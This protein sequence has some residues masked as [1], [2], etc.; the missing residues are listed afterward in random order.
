MSR[1]A[2]STA[3]RESVS[4]RGFALLIT[5]VL[6]AFLVLVLVSLASFTRVETRIAANTQAIGQARQ[7][8]LQALNIAFGQL[9]KYA[10]PDQRVTA[11][12][13]ISIASPA[14]G[15]SQW[16]GVWGNSQ[17]SSDPATSAV[18]LNWLVS[19]NEQADFTASMATTDFGR[20]TAPGSGVGKTPAMAWDTAGATATEDDDGIVL[21]RATSAGGSAGEVIAP[22]VTVTVPAGGL[23]GF[24]TSDTSLKTVG[25]YAYWV[26][27]EGLKARVNL[28][29]P[30]A[31][32]LAGHSLRESWV[33]AQR[34]GGEAMSGMGS[35][36][37]ANDLDL[38]KALSLSQLRFVSGGLS[39]AVVAGRFHDMTAVSRSVLAD[40]AA[41]GLKR[42]LTNWLA[43]TPAQLAALGTGVAPA[44]ADLIFEPSDLGANSAHTFGLPAWGLIRSF[45]ATR[46]DGATALAPRIQ[47]G[48]QQ[49]ISPVVTYARLGFSISG[50]EGGS[51]NVHLHPVVV[52]WNPYSAPIAAA[53]Y[54]LGFSPG[55]NTNRRVIDFR[56]G[57]TSGPSL[58]AVLLD[59]GT[60]R[61]SAPVDGNQT[62]GRY[63]TFRIDAPR[64]EPGQSHVLS[65]DAGTDSVS[66]PGM[67]TPPP[68][69]VLSTGGQVLTA[70]TVA[71]P[72]YWVATQQN[73]STPWAGG[74]FEVTLRPDSGSPS[75]FDVD[76]NAFQQIQNI[77]YGNPVM[78]A[79]TNLAAIGPLGPS[80]QLALTVE[81][82]MARAGLTF[83]NRWIAQHN[84]RASLSSR[85]QFEGWNYGGSYG[86]AN[87][88]YAGTFTSSSAA[89]A[90]PV[91][92]G[93]R[94]SAGLQ[95]QGATANAFVL[96]EFLPDGL[97]LMSPGQLQHA[98][99]ALL[100]IYPA[101]A[102]GNSHPNY[103]LAPSQVSRVTSGLVGGSASH[104]LMQ[105]IASVYDL[106][107]GLNR[108]LW[109]RYFFSTVPSSLS[110]TDLDDTGFKLPNARMAILRDGADPAD[111]RS[112]EAFRRAAARLLLEGAFNVNSTSVEAW[113]AVLS[114]VNGLPY[115]PVSGGTS[116]PLI[117]PVSR[118]AKP[119][120]GTGDM[121]RGYR[122]LTPAQIDQ[123]AAD[124]VVE[125]KARG[126][127]LSLADFVNRRLSGDATATAKGTLQAALDR[128]T[129][130]NGAVNLASDA[131]NTAYAKEVWNEPPGYFYID[132]RR[133][134]P[135]DVAPYGTLAAFAPGMVSQADILSQIGAT[136]TARSDT[137]RI[138]AYGESV[139][140]VTG[141]GEGK[142][143]C[144]A[145]VQRLPDY[146][147][148]DDAALTHGAATHPSLAGATNQ[149]LGRRFQVIS[150]RWL[151]PEDI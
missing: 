4:R 36:Y 135:A 110:Q 121:W 134:G 13:E 57:S 119:L 96:A 35:A 12:A 38:G 74:G 148:P 14:A 6:L 81:A 56:S 95:V 28:V 11:R 37:P 72:V 89:L 100:D 40:A 97:P 122:S 85:T 27:D 87:S 133:G 130:G 77:G 71:A 137:F 107:Y 82:H 94:A 17:A 106:S 8:S 44:D 5:I 30:G 42:D 108:A 115:D 75:W 29:D 41:G 51:L 129:S 116:S 92:A 118:F 151:S 26:G 63:F 102:V 7:Q 3:L 117:N 99:L 46:Y 34:V 143:W 64:L 142:A 9:Q 79:A 136:L 45:D 53:S 80:P 54:Q 132:Q 50:V 128:T 126:P 84:P 18:L 20:I 24:S 52:L 86:G 145:I 114:G 149:M 76:A 93:T 90:T 49:G 22:V 120:G 19:G 25:R 55:Y 91:F 101:H 47:T 150:F 32:S 124:I 131:P 48:T 61:A 144:E 109:D 65:Y 16:T 66:T 127:F 69:R 10:G 67:A 2:N 70:A 103:R 43:S 23:P 73:G 112:V 104:P 68:S 58:G 140:P 139:N 146:V 123:L 83:Q 105:R 59:Q 39:D 113:R 31:A 138:R 62:N 98:N 125:V 60:V 111:L 78:P 15:G 21:V 33:S 1:F 147:D 141:D 88:S